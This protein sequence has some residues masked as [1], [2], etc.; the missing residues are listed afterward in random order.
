[1]TGYAYVSPNPSFL[2]EK[3]RR[4]TPESRRVILYLFNLQH[5]PVLHTISTTTPPKKRTKKKNKEE[6][7]RRGKLKLKEGRK[8]RGKV[9][10][11]ERG[12]LVDTYAYVFRRL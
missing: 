11:E 12:T 1:M 5:I 8:A 2:I 7:K 3:Q 10:K 9:E 4:L 6:G